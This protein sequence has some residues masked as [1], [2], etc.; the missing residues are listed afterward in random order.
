VKT[1]FVQNIIWRHQPL[2]EGPGLFT[3]PQDKRLFEQPYATLSFVAFGGEILFTPPP[4][5]P[6]TTK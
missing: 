6:D 5:I 2:N 1:V 3:Q 4:K